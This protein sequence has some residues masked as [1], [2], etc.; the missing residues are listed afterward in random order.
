MLERL[1]YVKHSH[2]DF[3]SMSKKKRKILGF[4]VPPQM[5]EEFEALCDEENRTKSEV[6]REMFQA[7]KYLRSHGSLHELGVLKIFEKSKKE[8]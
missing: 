1:K 3:M 8:G 5:A 7:Y 4:S 6:F 2:Y